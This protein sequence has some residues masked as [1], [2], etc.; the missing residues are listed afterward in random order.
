M[1]TTTP[2]TFGSLLRR[3]RTEAALTQEELAER[4]ELSVRAISDLERGVNTAPRPFTVRRLADALVLDS[5]E[6]SEFQRAALAPSA[7]LDPLPQGRFLGSLPECTLIGREQEMARIAS[8]LHAVA[9]GAGHLALLAG[10]PASGKTRLLQE[11][12]LQ[13]RE[14]GFVVLTGSCLPADLNSPYHPLLEAFEPLVSSSPVAL[15][16]EVQNGWKAIGRLA[17]ANGTDRQVAA[18]VANALVHASNSSPVA[19]L[20]DDLQWA[21]RET[22]S[23]LHGVAR[24][25]R[26]TRT[27]LAAAFTDVE[28]AK[29]NR[30]LATTLQSLGRDRLADYLTV[31]RLSL[32]ET[33][34]LVAALMGQSDV[35]EEFA[36]FVYRR[37]KGSPRFIDELIRSLGGRLDLE[38]EI[39]AGSTGRVF[40]A[41]DRVTARTVAA[42]LVLARAG[43]DLDAL[44]RFQQEGAIL[45][46]LDHPNIVR[47]YDS[48]VEEHVGCI[49]MELLEG[50]SLA[51][52][53]ADGPVGLPRAKSIGT[54][55][56]GALAFAHSQSVVHRDVK[57]DN[58]M[59]LDDDVVKVTDFGIAR[60]LS[61]DTLIGTVATTGMRAGTPLYM[62]PEQIEGK[63]VDARSDVYALGA[64]LYHM[65]SGRPPFDGNDALEIAVKQ[66]KEQPAPPSS[67]QPG[68]PADWDALILKSLA[69]EPRR[70]FQSMEDMKRGIDS[71]GTD[72]VRAPARVARTRAL[73]PVSA[74]IL[75]VALIGSAFVYTNMTGQAKAAT[76]SSYLA[77]Q[78][79]G[80]KLSGTVLV[81][82]P[83][84]VLLDQGYGMANHNTHAVNT[85]N[86]QYALA[87][88]TSI[89]LLAAAELQLTQRYKVAE[90]Y[91]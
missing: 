85:P 15:D 72:I 41:Y 75:I 61:V 30:A 83:G 31:R 51:T 17:A 87:D 82:A 62:A 55:T 81:A 89:S 14:L 47:I 53:L 6:R 11:L 63:K 2:S 50:R 28:L 88:A 78:A 33:G 8:I 91:P 56:A 57:P 32:E 38:G 68:I 69:K 37:T 76:L 79:A 22:L 12:T 19:L 5:D 26:A 21:D 84:K 34:E 23:V 1:A 64:T 43:I 18:A 74:I 10:E 73:W 49:V 9:G 90:W 54:Q 4:A 27:L 71:L 66:I 20:L 45:R 35:S 86:T 65:V 48:F 52:V 59:I 58:V 67:V 3:Y 60:I 44:L 16:S 39:G 40:R 42:K 25:T 46:S 29:N 13:A 77:N 7:S 80:G 36:G 24:A 70:R